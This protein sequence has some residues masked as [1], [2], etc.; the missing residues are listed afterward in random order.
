ML[1]YGW[2]PKEFEELRKK[3]NGPSVN[4]LKVKRRADGVVPDMR[5]AKVRKMKITAPKASSVVS[6]RVNVPAAA[7]HCT[8]PVAHLVPAVDVEATIGGRSRAELQALCEQSGITNA[9]IKKKREAG[10][11]RNNEYTSHTDRCRRDDDYRAQCEKDGVP[12]W[13]VNS[14]CEIVRFDGRRGD[15]LRGPCAR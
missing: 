9:F 3:E 4:A 5:Q 12:E 13:L 2:T 10:A 1:H 14:K 6:E 7:A 11:R 15:E 8:V